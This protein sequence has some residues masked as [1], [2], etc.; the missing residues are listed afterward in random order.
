MDKRP[1]LVEKW[2]KEKIRAKKVK[3]MVYLRKQK[4]RDHSKESLIF[5]I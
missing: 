2:L 3:E 4:M 5:C 1:F